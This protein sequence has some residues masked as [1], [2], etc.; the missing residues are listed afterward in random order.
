[1]LYLLYF[2]NVELYLSPVSLESSTGR[3]IPPFLCSGKWLTALTYAKVGPVSILLHETWGWRPCL[4]NSVKAQTPSLS[5]TKW[6][7]SLLHNLDKIIIS[8][9]VQ[10]ILFFTISSNQLKFLFTHLSSVHLLIKCTG[11]VLGSRCIALSKADIA[12]SRIP[13]SQSSK[14]IRWLNKELH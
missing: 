11:S 14:G 6:T 5:L 10:Y 3:E 7:F 1:M 4:S 9:I 2:D 8:L 13:N 12:L